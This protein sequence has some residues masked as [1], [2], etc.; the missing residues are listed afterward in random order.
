MSDKLVAEHRQMVTLSGNLSEFQIKNLQAWPYVL[1]DKKDVDSVK[2]DYNFERSL[3]EED[4]E[5]I[6]Y[7]G[8]VEY[9]FKFKSEPPFTEETIKHKLQQLSHWVKYLFWEDTQVVIKKDGK[10]WEI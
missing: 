6:L 5:R 4:K 3:G 8:V 9:D 10:K 7:A 1:F 2:I